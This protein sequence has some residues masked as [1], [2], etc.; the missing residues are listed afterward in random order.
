MSSAPKYCPHY[1]VEDYQHWDGDWELWNGTAVSMSPSPFGPHE[2]AV[3]NLSWQIGTSITTHQC[4]CSVYTNLDWIVSSDTVVRPD[5]MLVCGPQPERHLERAPALVVEV[6]SESTRLKDE[7][8]KRELY[9][10]QGV[11][12]YLLADPEARTIRWMAIQ[13]NGTY[14]EHDT[15]AGSGA[16]SL[17]LKNGC[18]IDINC[19]TTFDPLPS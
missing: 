16:F 1:T 12:H 14:R 10:A 9:Q 15:S 11:E 17:T 13:P 7:T 2:R 5:V 3:S 6:L 18:K 4:A 19:G 8:A